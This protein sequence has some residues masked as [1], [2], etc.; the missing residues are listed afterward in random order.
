MPDYI[1]IGAG[2]AGCVLA[3][4]LSEDPNNTVLLLEAGGPATDPRIAIPAHY[5]SLF[6]SDIDWGYQS[7]PQVHLNNRNRLWREEA[8]HD[9]SH[10]CG[11]HHRGS[12]ERKGGIGGHIVRSV[13]RAREQD[14][15]LGV[16]CR[17]APSPCVQDRG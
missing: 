6:G 4:R 11:Q 3:N 17:L 13:Q 7:E 12:H 2:S 9:V 8:G 1:I 10:K 15:S 5:F 16:S 14:T